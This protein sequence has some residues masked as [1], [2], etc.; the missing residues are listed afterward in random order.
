VR[1]RFDR[2][3]AQCHNRRPQWCS[4]I[5]QISSSGWRA[6]VDQGLVKTG[7]IHLG[8]H[9]GKTISIR[10]IRQIFR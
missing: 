9:R 8:R 7:R 5:W 4:T 2:V 3:E 10:L 1:T 6:G